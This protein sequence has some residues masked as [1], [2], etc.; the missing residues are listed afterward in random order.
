MAHTVNNQDSRPQVSAV[1]PAYNEEAIIE[2]CVLRVAAVLDALTDGYEIVVTDDGSSDR[3]GEVLARIRLERPSAHLRVVTH[4]QNQGYGAALASGFDAA[5][6]ELIFMTDGDKQFDVT[7]LV[8]FLPALDDETDVVIGWRQQ[9]ADPPLRLLNAWLWK[10][11]VNALFGYTARDVDCAFKLFRREVWHSFTVESRGAT[12]SAEFLI[13]A[14][15]LGFRIKER[16]V[17]H[18]PRE[19]GSPT[20]AK[21]RVIARAL[22][23]IIH[24]RRDLN[25]QI[26]HDCRV[27]QDRRALALGG[28]K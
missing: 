24:L 5:T 18:Y 19:T 28:R 13:K 22:R 27:P 7:E 8:H 11:L 2:D 14:R 21:P 25:R 4:E 1:L 16:P 17:T 10:Q 23:D 12:F 15:R 3:T 9:R 26:R 20:G 6:G